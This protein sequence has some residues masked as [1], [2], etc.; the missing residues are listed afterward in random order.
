MRKNIL[1]V[2]L[3]LNALF[4]YA[5]KPDYSFVSIRVAKEQQGKRK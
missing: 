2:A 5:N 3:V 1:A 4:A